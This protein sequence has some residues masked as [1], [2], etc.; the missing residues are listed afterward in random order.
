MKVIIKRLEDV[1]YNF[2]DETLVKIKF[3]EEDKQ[4]YYQYRG[5][6]RETIE[7]M[8]KAVENLDKVFPNDNSMDDVPFKKKILIDIIDEP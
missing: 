6:I 7:Q 8:K 4:L 1:L 5:L 2:F 3:S